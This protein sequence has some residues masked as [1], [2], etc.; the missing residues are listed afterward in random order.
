MSPMFIWPDLVPGPSHCFN[1]NLLTNL[2]KLPPHPIMRIW[3]FWFPIP[4][5]ILE[6]FSITPGILLEVELFLCRDDPDREENLII[7]IIWLNRVVYLNNGDQPH[8]LETITLN[9]RF[10]WPNQYHISDEEYHRNI[11]PS[12]ISKGSDNTFANTNWS[13]GSPAPYYNSLSPHPPCFQP[14]EEEQ[15]EQNIT[16][17]PL[18]IINWVNERIGQAR[19]IAEELAQTI[20]WVHQGWDLDQTPFREGSLTY[21]QLQQIDQIHNPH[22][23]SNATDTA[24]AGP[25]TWLQQDEQHPER[26]FIQQDPEIARIFRNSNKAIN[27]CQTNT[28]H[29]FP[30]QRELD[31]VAEWTAQQSIPIDQN[32][33]RTLY[34]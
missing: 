33:P 12:N 24:V 22:L 29:T 7:I 2:S 18:E 32:L 9:F 27:T 26:G 23:Y 31:P 25:L 21:H 1:K 34:H 10:S 4:P 6:A 17:T 28:N 13:P 8:R 15:Q 3:E 20:Y 11:A 16:I 19:S 5:W 30:E 14:A